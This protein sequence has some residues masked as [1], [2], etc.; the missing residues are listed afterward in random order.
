MINEPNLPESRLYT[1]V[2]EAREYALYFLEGQRLIYEL[3]LLHAVRGDGFAYFRDVVLSIQPMIAFLKPGEQFGFYIDSDEPFFRLKIETGH[4]GETRS[5][6]L[7]ADFAQFPD[8]LRG[9]VRLQKIFPNNKLPYESLL[10]VE[11]LPLREIVNR[12]LAHSYQVNSAVIVSESSDQSVML[13]QLPP[14]PG[15]EELEYS[16][17]AVRARRSEVAGKMKSIFSRA[18]HEPDQIREAFAEIGFE[19]LAGRTIR[20]QCACSKDR[21]VQSLSLL[22]EGDRKDLYLP[23]EDSLEVV[24]EYC[25]SRYQVS[26]HELEQAADPFN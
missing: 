2:D 5:A 14:F 24:C 17:D 11:D 12:V 16:E 25:K 3:A 9:T 1:F 21:V 13:N 15:K 10:E 20:F 19:L 26:R 6:I 18:L 23:G 4:H 22:G 8:T 7:P